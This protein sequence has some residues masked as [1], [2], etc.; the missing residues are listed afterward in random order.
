MMMM[1]MMTTKL[2]PDKKSLHTDPAT[3]TC[4]MHPATPTCEMQNRLT[5]RRQARVVIEFQNR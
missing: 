2:H 3:P 5:P 4:E 1:M